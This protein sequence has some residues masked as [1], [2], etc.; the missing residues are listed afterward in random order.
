VPDWTRHTALTF[1][2]LLHGEIETSNAEKAD[3]EM[4]WALTPSNVDAGAK[5]SAK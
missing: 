5:T 1:H 2:V 3:A 4:F